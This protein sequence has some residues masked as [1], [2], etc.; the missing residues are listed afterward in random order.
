[1]IYIP[2]DPISEEDGW[3]DPSADMPPL[4]EEEIDEIERCYEAM[5]KGQ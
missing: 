5:R 4:T 2:P 3:I 1:M